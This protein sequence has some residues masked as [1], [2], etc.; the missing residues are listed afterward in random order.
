MIKGILTTAACTLAFNLNAQIL[1]MPE[2]FG[3]C[4]DTIPNI[5]TVVTGTQSFTQ[6]FS[7]FWICAGDTLNITGANNT[8]YGERGSAVFIV[9]AEN[10][11]L[12]KEDGHVQVDTGNANFI[13]RDSMTT[14]VDNGILDQDS[15]CAVAVA[16]EYSQAPPLGCPPAGLEPIDPTSVTLYPNPTT[17]FIHLGSSAHLFEQASVISTAGQQGLSVQTSET[18]DLSSLPDGCYVIRLVA[19]DGFVI[20]RKVIVQR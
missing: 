9:G 1:C 20:H 8:I 6:G 16:F 5:A 14:F 4:Q 17:G 7:C 2:S 10:I 3:R 13:Y 12:M 11:V 18:V 15:I 19:K